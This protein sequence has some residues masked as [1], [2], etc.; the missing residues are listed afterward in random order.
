MSKLAEKLTGIFEKNLLDQLFRTALPAEKC[1]NF[2]HG[3][4]AGDAIW[5]RRTVEITSHGQDIFPA[6]GE[7]ML[8]MAIQVFDSGV[9][10]IAEK[11]RAEI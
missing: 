8:C 3:L 4:Y 2:F 10:A 7:K 6:Q 1:C 11:I 9:S 5:K